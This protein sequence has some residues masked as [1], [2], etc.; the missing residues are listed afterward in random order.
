MT[1]LPLQ[2]LTQQ[3]LQQLSTWQLSAEDIL[4]L[5]GLSTDI[6]PRHLQSY[7][8]GDRALPDSPEL[9]VRLEH[10]VGISEALATTFPFSAEM[11]VMWLRRPH[12]RFQSQTPLA[13]MMTEGVD[14]LQ[15]VRMD[16]D[17][18]YSYAIADAMYAAQ[19]KSS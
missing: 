5:L 9:Q 10:L 18:A 11:R 14:G 1:T 4:H 15:K 19:Q 13:V 8:K 6:K 17:C 12:R 7:L 2:Q 3:V 16:V